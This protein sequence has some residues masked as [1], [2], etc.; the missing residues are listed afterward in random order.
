M[1]TISLSAGQI[2]HSRVPPSGGGGSGIV[3]AFNNLR[4]KTKV[5]LGFFA[6]L[7]LLIVLAV[8]AV[9]SFSTATGSFTD[10]GRVSANTVRVSGIER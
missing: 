7:A 8:M 1:P 4:V 9:L 3:R 2:S 6:V 10:Y 5:T